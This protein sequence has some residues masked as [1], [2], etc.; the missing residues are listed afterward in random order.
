MPPRTTS[1]QA[2]DRPPARGS[3]ASKQR[4]RIP[5]CP[6]YGQVVLVLAGLSVIGL[7][8]VADR[9]RD[10]EAQS[11][12][13]RPCRSLP[14]DVGHGRWPG[15][16]WRPYSTASPFNRRIP[17]RP[18]VHPN[19]QRMVAKVL[20]FGP[21]QHLRAGQDEGGNP[22]YYSGRR[23]PLY[24]LGCLKPWGRCAI[25]GH[26]IRVPAPARAVTGSD[27]HMTVIDPTSGWEYDLWQVR[28]K[29][30]RGGTLAFS[31]GGRTR[32]DGHG[33]GSAATAA[34]FGNMAGIVRAEELE[35]GHIQHALLLVVRCDNGKHVY[36]AESSGF[37]CSDGGGSN[38]D[39]PPMGSLFQ[40][41][42][43]D[44]EIDDLE[45]PRWKKTILRA[46]ARYGMF[47]GDTGGSW[48][49][50]VESDLTYTSFGHEGR[51]ERFAKRNGWTWWAPDRVWVGNLRDG[52]DWKNRLRV[53]DPCVPRRS[54]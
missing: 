53:L 47:L 20:G 38:A 6:R 23:D 50:D 5:R 46:M 51:W 2:D 27:A 42:M 45:V 17:A 8:M 41:A 31:W 37:A 44:A 24:R 39:A 40:L 34:H 52:V 12:P 26:R 14:P 33:L 21:L 32:I 36:P 15:A 22:T 9:R 7:V 48:A 11:A 10:R 35:A 1:R 18:R 29:P 25:E 30:R 16:C 43:S 49:I 54:C 19:S 28:S 13:P 4:R 3:Q